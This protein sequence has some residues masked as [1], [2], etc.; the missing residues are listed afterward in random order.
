MNGLQL[1]GDVTV[2]EPLLMWQTLRASSA[3]KT[4]NLRRQQKFRQHGVCSIDNFNEWLNYDFVLQSSNVD[5]LVDKYLMILHL[6]LSD[7]V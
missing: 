6:L 3:S 4:L 2:L 5:G 7:L 1:R